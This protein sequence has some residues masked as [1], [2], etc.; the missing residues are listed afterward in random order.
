MLSDVFSGFTPPPYPYDR[1]ESVAEIAKGHSGGMVDLSVGTPID[2]PIKEVVDALSS[3]DT[4]RGY[5]T[6]LGSLALRSSMRE[7]L[8]RRFN[9]DVPLANIA[10]CIGT[11]EFVASTPWYL[12]LRDPSKDTVLY[13]AVSYP[14]YALGAELA[15]CRAVPVAVGE[16]GKLEL[17]SI[18]R[19]DLDRAVMVWSNSPS[20]P[21]GELDDL[22]ALYVFANETG[23]PVFSDEC[24]S[25][26]TW[27]TLP[28]SILKYG[29]N[30]VVAVHSLS[31]RS[32]LAGIRVGFY[33][34]DSGI[35][36]YLSLVRKH[37]GMMIPGPMQYGASIAFKDDSHVEAQRHVYH[38]RL[39]F[40][41][42]VFSG[43]GYDVSIPKGGFYLWFRSELDD[44]FALAAELA[45]ELGIL[46]S[47]GEF[48]G[49]FSRPFVRVAMVADMSK[50]E[51]V[52][53]RAKNRDRY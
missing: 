9:V 12:K 3:S 21:T 31:K 23:V 27:S 2:P 42:G 52:A 43:L 48:Y 24:Y 51:L 49:A 50:L 45:R 40:M 11:K 14:T 22:K 44:G 7:W 15:Q 19:S 29:S 35:V 32:N 46:V 26:F 34:G 10:S 17:E 41:V 36:D 25:E 8:A 30:N 6:S 1:L 47:P 18:S 16:D 33:A 38:D 13:P 5:P 4:E 53:Q 39:G 28:D 37:A 20:N